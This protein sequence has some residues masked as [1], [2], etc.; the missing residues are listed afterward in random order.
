MITVWRG[1]WTPRS[2]EVRLGV[3]DGAAANACVNLKHSQ[4]A[5]ARRCDVS[6]PKQ[7]DALRGPVTS[8]GVNAAG[9][10]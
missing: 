7:E 3:Q 5:E 6:G 10:Q 9:Q 2:I 4:E 1:T 8:C